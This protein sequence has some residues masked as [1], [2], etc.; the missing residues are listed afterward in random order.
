MKLPNHLK[1][2]TNPRL[3]MNYYNVSNDHAIHPAVWESVRGSS[4]GTG[5]PVVLIDHG[6]CTTPGDHVTCLPSGVCHATTTSSTNS[7]CRVHYND[8]G[9]WGSPD[10]PRSLP[11]ADVAHAQ[12]LWNDFRDNYTGR[13]V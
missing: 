7:R 5:R 3:K 12:V 6:V 9:A 11:S 1:V 10:C 8:T 4:W 13:R 2:Y